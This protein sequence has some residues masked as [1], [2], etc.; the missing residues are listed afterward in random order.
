MKLHNLIQMVV[1][2]FPVVNPLHC[3]PVVYFCSS[4]LISPKLLFLLSWVLQ[5][6]YQCINTLVNSSLSFHTEEDLSY[7][8]PVVYGWCWILEILSSNYIHIVSFSF[9]YVFNLTTHVH[10][11]VNMKLFSKC[12][13]VTI[14]KVITNLSKG[15]FVVI[16]SLFYL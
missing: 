14:C 11:K 8:M 13:K 6:N 1:Y 7:S 9:F 10:Y 5:V 3:L 4:R 16:I 2:S 12:M 15:Q